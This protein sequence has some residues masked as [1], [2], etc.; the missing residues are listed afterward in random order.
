MYQC[1]A[2]DTPRSWDLKSWQLKFSCKQPYQ[3]TRNPKLISKGS[4][5]GAL[6]Y[7]CF[8]SPPLHSHL[9]PLITL[10][11]PFPFPFPFFPCSPSSLSLALPLPISSCL[12]QLLFFSS[13]IYPLFVFF[14]S[15]NLT[16]IFPRTHTRLY[17]GHTTWPVGGTWPQ[18]GLK[19]LKNQFEKKWLTLK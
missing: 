11:L 1:I 5:C 7:F 10:F 6:L 8:P 19:I 12:Y 4:M 3:T 17:L 16:Q 15:S 2:Q 18:A 13:Y 9:P 14:S